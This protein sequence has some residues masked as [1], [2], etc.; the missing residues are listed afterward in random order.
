M[1][2]VKQLQG[3]TLRMGVC[4]G[5]GGPAPAV[6]C[7]HPLMVIF[8][9][10][11]RSSAPSHTLPRSGPL[12][13]CFT[14]PQSLPDSLTR[15]LIDCCLWRGRAGPSRAEPGGAGTSPRGRRCGFKTPCVRQ[16]EPLMSGNAGESLAMSGSCERCSAVRLG[17]V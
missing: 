9:T 3:L 16:R 8:C 11:L 15:R 4:L 13:H 1:N 17:P 14:P 7:S 12:P 6:I 5:Q 10:L 2:G